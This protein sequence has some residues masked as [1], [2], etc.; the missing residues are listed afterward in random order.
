MREARA[1]QGRTRR[2]SE[3]EEEGL[4]LVA[5]RAKERGSMGQRG[6]EELGQLLGVT[7]DRAD[8]GDQGK[9]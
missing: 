9:Q 1:Y 4:T 8:S 3:E 6:Q 7:E 5:V 2:A